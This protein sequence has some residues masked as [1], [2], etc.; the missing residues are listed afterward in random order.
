MQLNKVKLQV[1]N[2]EIYKQVL[3]IFCPLSPFLL[4][5]NGHLGDKIII[6][7]FNYEIN[8]NINYIL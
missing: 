3:L 2:H 6:I 8:N 5:I 4:Y 1:E 7:Y